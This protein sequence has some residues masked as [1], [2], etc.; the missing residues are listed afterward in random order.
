VGDG[1]GPER[2]SRN[3]G[4]PGGKFPGDESGRDRDHADLVVP[5]G[6]KAILSGLTGDPGKGQDVYLF[7]HFS[8][9]A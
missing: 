3:A 2:L 4:K 7:H 5:S 9:M 8:S 1:S 6:A